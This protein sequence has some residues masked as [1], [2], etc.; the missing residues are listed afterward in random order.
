LLLVITSGGVRARAASGPPASA[1]NPAPGRLHA[2]AAPAGHLPRHPHRPAP[3]EHP[4]QA[5]AAHRATVV[6]LA[7]AGLGLTVLLS[8]MVGSRSL[9]PLE[10]LRSVLGPDG[11]ETSA[12]VRELRVPR[13]VVGLVVG[14]ALGLAGA[15]LQGLTRNPLADPGLLGVSAGA[16]LA[17]VGTS[18]VLGVGGAAGQVWAALLGALLATFAVWVL[19]GSGRGGGS[20]LPLVLAGVALTALLSSLTTVLVL[21][22]AD[23]L[24]EYRFWAA[25]SVAG[26]DLGLL[27]TVAPF[28]LLGLLLAVAGSRTL[29]L[30]ALGD[31]LAT[32]LGARV[33]WGRAGVALSA[34]LLTAGSVAL[35]GPVVFVGLVVP[36]V[37]RALVGPAHR[38]LLPLSAVLGAVLL[39]ASDVLGRVV[40]R[41]GEIQAGIVTAAVGV[42][43]L[44]ALVRRR[45]DVAA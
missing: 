31:D 10:V 23:T 15:Q 45:R 6:L 22:D 34:A 38:W 9:P 29:D 39:I 18:T 4:D 26:R 5:A 19:A 42:P 3:A 24:N 44:I 40:A 8:L 33:S 1:G 2:T 16:S 25:G 13:T 17:V 35:A 14:A 11:S 36:H 20:P 7:V 43:F 28:L 21:L 41:P 12:I 32:G 37:A 30:L 27:S